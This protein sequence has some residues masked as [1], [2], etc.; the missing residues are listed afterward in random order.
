MNGITDMKIKRK[1][2]SIFLLLAIMFSL[3]T[4]IFAINTADTSN[5]S[6]SFNFE[7]IFAGNNI[8]SNFSP[9]TL[10]SKNFIKLSQQSDISVASISN[11]TYYLNNRFEGNFLHYSHLLLTQ[12]PEHY[13]LF[14]QALNGLL[15]ITIPPIV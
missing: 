1:F 14:N 7:D 9:N 13:L 5:N 11:G 10:P 6:L 12:P 8:P 15:Q 4:S 3:S 2:I